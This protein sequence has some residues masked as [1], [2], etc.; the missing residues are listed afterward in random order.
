MKHLL[1][2]PAFPDIVGEYAITRI[3]E[4][5]TS[6]STSA[7]DNGDDPR[8]RARRSFVR[9]DGAARNRR[10]EVVV[11]T[12]RDTIDRKAR[13]WTVTLG[14]DGKL[15]AELNG[16]AARLD[17]PRCRAQGS[18]PAAPAATRP[19]CFS[20]AL[21]RQ[22][23]LV[24]KP[25]LAQSRHNPCAA[26]HI[27]VRQAMR[28]PLIALADLRAVFVGQR[29]PDQLLRRGILPSSSSI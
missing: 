6:F 12:A 11:S 5:R 24:D 1:M 9:G 17:Q 16:G 25:A 29:R 26:D 27:A 28:S 4:T 3:T 18:T 8:P 14:R 22:R 15:A 7:N 13:V 23:V 20:P 21:G 19:R 10:D 2:D